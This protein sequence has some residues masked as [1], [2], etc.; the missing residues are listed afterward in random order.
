MLSLQGRVTDRFGQPVNPLVPKPNQST[1]TLSY[2]GPVPKILAPFPVPNTAFRRYH[3]YHP[4]CTTVGVYPVRVEGG[5][6]VIYMTPAQAIFYLESFW[7]GTIAWLSLPSGTRDTIYQL[8]GWSIPPKFPPVVNT[9]LV[10]QTGIVGTPVTPYTFPANAFWSPEDHAVPLVYSAT[11]SQV[12]YPV[13]YALP[14]W[15]QFNQATRTFSGTPTGTAHVYP[16]RVTAMDPWSQ[17]VYDEFNY[18][19]S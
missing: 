14:N 9:P 8:S 10:N 1:P 3:V 7:I 12:G 2:W 15:L 13:Q 6:R 19:I 17:T 11:W 4:S 16:I 5:V 18:T